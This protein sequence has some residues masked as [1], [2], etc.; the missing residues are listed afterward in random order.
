MAFMFKKSLVDYIKKI[1]VLLVEA[2][3]SFRKNNDLTAASSLAFSAMLALIP[4]LFL[5]TFVLSGVVGSSQEAIARTQKLLSE[6]IPSY[7][8]EI[9]REVKV[10]SAHRRTMGIVNLVVLL[11]MV[12][13]FVSEMRS[14]LGVI[15]RKRPKRHFILQKLLDVSITAVF[16]TGLSAVAVVGVLMA[17]LEKSSP[18][19]FLPG[20][21]KSLGPFVVVTGVVFAL[22][23]IFSP[24]IKLKHIVAG[25]LMTSVLW[26][27]MRPAFTLFLT[28]NPGY[29]VA[30]GSFKSLFVVIIWIYYSLAVFLFG[31]E[32]A[33]NLHRKDAVFVRR[34][35]EGRRGVPEAVL[36]K[37]VVAFDPGDVIF[38]EG[39]HGSEMYSVRKGNVSIRRGDKEIALIGEGSF[40]GEMSFLLGMPRSATAV[41]ADETELIVISNNTVGTLMNE[42]PEFVLRMLR[43]MAARLRETNRYVS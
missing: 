37:F 40:F 10:L 39:D 21:A 3:G 31:A 25:A 6:V 1:W 4:A 27:I 12:T 34:L 22:Y 26:S 7:G 14:A 29:G 19:G 41:A 18:L 28:Y 38:L 17:V 23:F 43:E 30:F 8:D 11:W 24:R 13:P 20:Y 42:F 16:L 9:L 33:A 15:F 5:F 2:F 36:R 32:V 35:M